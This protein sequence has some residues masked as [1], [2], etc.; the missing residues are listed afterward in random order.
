MSSRS[1]KIKR[2]SL[3]RE[4]APILGLY[5]IYSFVRWFIVPENTYEAF[6]NAFK[7]IQLERRFGVFYE[8]IIQSWL[9]DH[10]RGVIQVAN[11]FYTLGYLP[12]LIL[13]G[14]LLYR[15]EPGR[16]RIFQRTFL[17]GLGLALITYSLLPVAP[18]RMLPEM[19]FV[20]TQQA[21]SSNLYNQK[22]ILSLYNPYAAMPSLHF[23]WALLLG[24][25]AYSFERPWFK[26]AGVLYPLGM[27]LVI[28]ITGNH[29]FLDIVGAG[30]VVGLSYTL[31]KALPY[32]VNRLTHKRHMLT[33]RRGKNA[34][35]A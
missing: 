1:G 28:V 21:Y 26:I 15:F 10:A 22:I 30:I 19:G 33:V 23:G 6:R 31:A 27:A 17:L 16:F 12:V 14:V 35:I 2:D 29:Y 25:M 34:S 24:M 3:L 13:C 11:A 32:G 5:S 7:I 4:I 18:P 20:D 9:I 8:A